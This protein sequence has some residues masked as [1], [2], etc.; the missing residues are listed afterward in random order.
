MK[1]KLSYFRREGLSTS[2][3]MKVLE[4]GA[5]LN[6]LLLAPSS[7]AGRDVVIITDNQAFAYEFQ[8]GKK[9]R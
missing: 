7:L 2:A 9:S 6:G 5:S 3:L 1:S 8:N 4:A